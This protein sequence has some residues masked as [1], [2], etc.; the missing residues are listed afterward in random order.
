MNISLY[1]HHIENTA[2]RIVA[3]VC[4]FAVAAVAMAQTNVSCHWDTNGVDLGR[5]ATIQL[6]DQLNL[7]VLSAIDQPTFLSLDDIASGNDIVALTVSTDT[8]TSTGAVSQLRQTFV[9]TSFRPGIHTLRLRAVDDSLTLTV[10]D[11]LGDDTAQVEL[12]D[13]ADIMQEKLTFWDVARYPVWVLMAAAVVLLIVY[14]VRRLR[15]HQPVIAR[16]VA[17]PVP[18]RTQAL[19]DLEELRR[20]ELWQKGRLKEYYT[21]LTDI[22]RLYIKQKYAVDSVEMTTEQTLDAFRHCAGNTEGRSAL[23]A[24]IL[25][26]A[27]LVKFAKAEPL[28]HEHDRC[29][30]EAVDFVGLEEPEETKTEEVHS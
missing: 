16:P 17:P 7:I 24:H 12:R 28:A 29:M 30:S 26:T 6:G 1:I 27:D 18:P 4:C 2:R 15:Q 3:L 22:V 20:Q 23:L 10:E 9:I 5:H 25:T 19:A 14:V 8:A 13:I 11:V 21:Q